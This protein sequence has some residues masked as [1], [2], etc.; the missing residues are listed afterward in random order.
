VVPGH[1]LTLNNRDRP[2]TFAAYVLNHDSESTTLLLDQ[3]RAV[4]VV[5]RDELVPD[6]PFCIPQQTGHWFKIRPTQ[7]LG[8]DPDVPSP[9]EVCPNPSP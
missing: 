7:V 4:I 9:Y 5:P 8:I 1:T 2:D 3:P 6:M